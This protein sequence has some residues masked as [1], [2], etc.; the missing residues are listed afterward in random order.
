M[1]EKIP[2]EFLET[3]VIRTPALPFPNV[4]S[5]EVMAKVQDN[6]MF[7]E[8]IFL[9]SPVLYHELCKLKSGNSKS[10]KE[11]KKIKFSLV[12]YYQRMSSRCTP[13][14]LFSGCSVVKWHTGNTK[15]TFDGFANKHTRLDMDYLC[16]LA[17]TL[18]TL[19]CLKE[20]LLY[21]P[22]N[23]IYTIGD[24][25]RYVE[26]K[27]KNGLRMHQISSVANTTYLKTILAEA[28]TGIRLEQVR[29]LLEKDVNPEEAV[30]YI[31][32]LLASQILVC[33]LEPSVTG[34]EVTY[35]LLETMKKFAG[36]GNSELSAITSMFENIITRLREIEIS[37]NKEAFDFDEIITLIR[38]LNIEYEESKLFQADLFKK[39]L[40]STVNNAIQ[41]QILSAL[42]I[43]N[44]LYPEYNNENLKS[45]VKRFTDRY[46]GAA[47]SLSEVLDTETGI[48]YPEP[49]S[50]DISPLTE[51]LLLP[52]KDAESSY[53]IRWSKT[54]QWLFEKLKIADHDNSYTIQLT[55]ED[56]TDNNVNW[57]NLPPSLAALFRMVNIDNNL[58]TAHTIK[59]VIESIAGSSAANLL[60]RFAHGD[61][62]IHKTIC[63]LTEKEQ[64]LNPDIVFAEIVHLP[65][66]RT[67]NVLLRPAFRM[68]E[69][70]YLAMSS[71][72][73]E[74]QLPLSD[75][76]ISVEGERINIF[77][78]KLN[79]QIIPRLSTAHNFRS[80]A[81]P[82]YQFL[83]DLQSQNLRT[84]FA[85][86]W[87]SMAKHFKFLPRVEYKNVILHE[88][89]WQF[90]KADLEEFVTAIEKDQP[91]VIGSFLSRW[92]LPRYFVLADNDNELLADTESSL[93]LQVFADTIKNRPS[94]IL[95]EF[96]FD[97]SSAV[98][99]QKG[100]FF[101]NQ[102]IAP[103]I[104][105]ENVYASGIIPKS[106]KNTAGFETEFT[107]GSEWLYYKFYCGIKSADKILIDLVAPLTAK[108]LKEKILSKWFYVRYND[109]AF[110]IRVRFHLIDTKDTGEVIGQITEMIKETVL[111]KFIWKIQIDTYH[112]EAERYGSDSMEWVEELFY[113]DS[114][115]KLRFLELT[116]GDE[117]ENFRWLW[118]LRTTDDLLNAFEYTLEQK[119]VLLRNLKESFG[120]E[121][122][123]GKTLLLQL[124]R[125]Y[126][127]YKQAI[128]S[129]MNGTE[130][131]TSAF[132]NT[133]F[134]ESNTFLK[135]IKPILKKAKQANSS[136][137]SA[138]SFKEKVGSF[139][140]MSLNRLF[141]SQARLQEYIIYEFLNRWYVSVIK[142]T[143]EVKTKT[144]I[145]T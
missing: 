60:G 43:L 113:Y 115:N 21:Y 59:I 17:Q 44:N 72:S 20:K 131:K 121:F 63:E 139:I 96:L 124:N 123:A 141:T 109:P 101:V 73:R 82:V 98:T 125:K 53:S 27:Y 35:Q 128:N 50:Q 65:E 116:E 100:E 118:G 46:E 95:K 134:S 30:D 70:P 138:D 1:P 64:A 66:D 11:I 78:I 145:K 57:K 51:E 54:Q 18:A 92:R 8:A 85:F 49:G 47:M 7:S 86:H 111:A 56:F 62:G 79:K 67:G 87:G 80:N 24:E 6:D 58:A 69:I 10:E 19:P 120:K 136:T 117:R 37:G 12:K 104:K 9:A 127:N 99:N 112:R 137:D 61:L 4:I 22:N 3:L 68:Y 76:L 38:G 41:A 88:A 42:T 15:I 129:I 29:Q 114:L 75:L 26:Y 94:I 91:V 119:Q 110:H 36:D 105:T 106:S 108:L 144:K 84:G 77:S 83:C 39:T 97:Q 122:Y 143:P 107:P 45:F 16:A 126:N 71:V 142:Q 102:F 25:L 130:N 2:Y 81:L 33:E 34:S 140:H 135:I 40:D 28:A 89:R 14:G 132:Y 74:H 48:G 13:F 133:I 103:L 32:E 93:S 52:Q 55:D 5:N 90:K 31:N 23:S